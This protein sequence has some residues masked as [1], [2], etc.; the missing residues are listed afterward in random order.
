MW[1]NPFKINVMF[2]FSLIL[3]TLTSAS[4]PL[5]QLQLRQLRLWLRST[6]K[7]Q[8]Q[9]GPGIESRVWWP[10]LSGEF[11]TAAMA[12]C[13]YSCK[14]YCLTNSLPLVWPLAFKGR[15]LTQ[16]PTVQEQRFRQIQRLQWRQVRLRRRGGWL[17]RRHVRVSAVK[18]L[19]ESGKGA[20]R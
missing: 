3:F 18:R 20:A 11:R 14:H 8:R 9:K 13:L 1:T 6:G 2:Y 19:V 17:W 7:V 5:K 4:L 10:V 15:Q 16:V 12:Q